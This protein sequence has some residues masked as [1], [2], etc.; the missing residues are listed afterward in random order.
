[1]KNPRRKYK[2]QFLHQKKKKK[3]AKVGR[4]YLLAFI[5]DK[6]KEYMWLFLLGSWPLTSAQNLMSA[7][8]K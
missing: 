2:P 3:A 7:R 5:I 4:K 6:D 1:M 8:K